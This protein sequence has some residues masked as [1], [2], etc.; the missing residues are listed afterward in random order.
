MAQDLVQ[1]YQKLM[2]NID[3]L[4]ISEQTDELVMRISNIDRMIRDV[5]IEVENLNFELL[6]KKVSL[7][8]VER[9]EYDDM[10]TANQVIKEF[11]PYIIW[12]N[13]HKKLRKEMNSKK[14]GI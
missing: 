10:V 11:S 4:P 2:D 3:Q 6:G 9:Q 13:L 8:P 14:D 1:N 7:T 5:N 12:Y